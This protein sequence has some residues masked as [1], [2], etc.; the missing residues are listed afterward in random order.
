MYTLTFIVSILAAIQ[1]AT[2]AAIHSS[3]VSHAARS[4]PTDCNPPVSPADSTY[5]LCAYANSEEARGNLTLVKTYMREHAGCRTISG[6]GEGVI[7]GIRCGG[8]GPEIITEG[9]PG[10]SINSGFNPKACTPGA[11]CL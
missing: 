7:R 11:H 4:I 8:P 2:A 1:S 10:W 3:P 6:N 5:G 9:V